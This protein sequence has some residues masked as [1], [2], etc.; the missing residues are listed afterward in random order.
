MR[1]HSDRRV[2]DRIEADDPGLAAMFDRFTVRFADQAM[3]QAEHPDRRHSVSVLAVLV[4]VIGAALVAAMT[5]LAIATTS[6]NLARAPYAKLLRPCD[7]HPVDALRVP[8]SR[9]CK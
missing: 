6:P 1:S 3:P 2:L 5:G 4:F 9:S 8:I 7:G